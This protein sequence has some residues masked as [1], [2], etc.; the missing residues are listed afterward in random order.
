MLTVG[1]AP[2]LVLVGPSRAEIGPWRS[3]AEHV[4]RRR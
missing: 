4:V 2:G 1:T 3:V